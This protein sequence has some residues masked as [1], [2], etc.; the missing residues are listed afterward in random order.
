MSTRFGIYRSANTDYTV[1][2]RLLEMAGVAAYIVLV[3]LLAAW[4]VLSVHDGRTALALVGA[5]GAGYLLADFVSGLV[6]WAGDTIGDERTPVLGKSFIRSFREHHV[7]PKDITRHDFLEVNGNNCLIS[8]PPLAAAWAVAPEL[9]GSPYSLS[10]VGAVL[11]LTLA[12][13]A[14]NQFHKWAHADRVPTAVRWLQR[15]RLILSPEHHQ[16][17]HTPPFDTYYC[18]TTGWW[19]WT[20]RQFK[21]LRGIEWAIARVWGAQAIHR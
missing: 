17:H 5:A 1:V 4:C 19:N 6:H 9:P 20:L 10:A 8:L 16:I 15:R 13:F 3:G 18:I 2:H 11:C 12:V 7:D 14:T 21:V